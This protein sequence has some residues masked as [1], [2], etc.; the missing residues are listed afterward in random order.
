MKV[1][2]LAFAAFV[3]LGAKVTGAGG[4]RHCPDAQIDPATGT[5]LSL[6]G[7]SATRY[8]WGFVDPQGFTVTKAGTVVLSADSA[9]WVALSTPADGF[10]GWVPPPID[11]CW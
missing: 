5:A 3:P 9:Y 2:T 6:F 1:A 11:N 7:T 10:Q 4:P 8:E